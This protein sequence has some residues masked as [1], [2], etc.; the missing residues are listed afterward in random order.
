M[1]KGFDSNEILA[2]RHH[3]ETHPSFETTGVDT[4]NILGGKGIS[5]TEGAVSNGTLSMTGTEYR[6]RQYLRTLSPQE[7]AAVARRPRFHSIPWIKPADESE[8]DDC[9]P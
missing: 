8:P 6:A 3:V 1:V 7:R 9:L 2:T 5:S 4:I